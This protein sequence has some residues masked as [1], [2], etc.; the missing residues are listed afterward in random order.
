MA[1]LWALATA[2][3]YAI[4]GVII[5]H[6]CKKSHPLAVSLVVTISSI[7]CFL[8]IGL[9]GPG[10]HLEEKYYHYGILIGF[11]FALG[12]VIEYKAMSIGPMATVAM[13]VSLAPVV[14]LAFDMLTG[15][16]PSL[17]QYAGF[18]LVAV[19]LLLVVVK[20]KVTVASSPVMLNPYLLAIPA[21]LMFGLSDVIF[22]LADS[23]SIV[24]LLLLIQASKL[25]TSL[26]IAFPI[27]KQLR[28]DTL[29]IIRLLP[30]GIIY[31]LGWIALD[32]SARQGSID[33]TSALEY[34]S[35][36]FVA[37]L[38]YVFLR[39]RLT[40]S[41]AMGFVSALVGIIFLVAFPAAQ[42]RTSSVKC[43]LECTQKMHHNRSKMLH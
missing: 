7:F 14:P 5:G 32:W 3:A 23:A 20:R 33:I 25:I 34:T 10:I 9:L 11:L 13:T 4:G 12:N 39:E 36:I 35:P 27:V 16:A 38:A 24:G 18:L 21:S 29:P 41:Q 40:R 2:I 37:I 1:S 43:G 8:L 17:P 15:K 19:G 42:H 26:L 30:V 28:I 31:S 6:A 22:G